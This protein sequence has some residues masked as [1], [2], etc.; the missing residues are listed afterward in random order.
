MVPP[1]TATPLGEF[2]SGLF[3]TGKV[4]VRRK[5]DLTPGDPQ[6]VTLL[7]EAYEATIDE[8]RDDGVQA[9][10]F[11]PKAAL[12]ALRCVY[13]LCHALVDRALSEGEVEAIFSIIP[14]APVDAAE[15]LSADVV[16]RH[17]PAIQQWAKSLSSEDPL[18]V[19]MPALGLRFPLS[20]VG[21][22]ELPLPLDLTLL[23]HH[24]GLWRL[25]IDRVIE[26]QDT[27]RL[28]DPDVKAAV[29]DAL[30][31]HPILAPRLAMAATA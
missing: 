18:V 15:M 19:G 31:S 11:K 23:R 8:L 24:P 1:G 12:E 20:S 2:A 5:V 27:S 22:G 10:E 21:M 9:P 26:R 4:V 17:L 7:E 16:L 25:Y 6:A 29:R 28:T 30:G 3:S 14:P 13:R